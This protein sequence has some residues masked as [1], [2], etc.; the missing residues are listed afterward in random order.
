MDKI[1]STSIAVAVI[2]ALYFS[3]MWHLMLPVVEIAYP[4]GQCVRVVSY[5]ENAKYSCDNLPK[6]YTQIYVYDGKKPD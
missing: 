6:K 2:V 3:I 4:S 5:S 1:I